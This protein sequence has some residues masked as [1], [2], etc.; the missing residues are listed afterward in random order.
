MYTLQVSVGKLMALR[1]GINALNAY[2]DLSD[3]SRSLLSEIIVKD[4]GRLDDQTAISSAGKRAR[5][6]SRSLMALS[7][8]G[9]V[10]EENEEEEQS[11][12]RT[13]YKRRRLA[14]G[15][16]S[17]VVSA[18]ERRGSTRGSTQASTVSPDGESSEEDIRPAG[19]I[20]RS[21]SRGIQPTRG[22]RTANGRVTRSSRVKTHQRLSY[23]EPTPGE[24]SEADEL[25][26]DVP[27][28]DDD[29]KLAKR[30]STSRSL[31][32]GRGRG[33]GRG[34]AKGRG[35]PK[36]IVRR[37]RQST[38]LDSSSSDRPEPTRRSGRTT[39]V[40]KSMKEH[41]EDEEVYAEERDAASGP[42]VISIREVFQPL[43]A[44]SPFRLI[45]D[46][47]C[48]VCNGLETASNK[49]TASPLIYCQGCSTSIHKVCLG[50]RSGRE[51]AVTKVGVDNFVMQ[52]RRCIGTA[53]K[54]DYNAPRL[55]I[56]QICKKSGEACESFSQKK[57]AKQ[58]EK[59]REENGGTDP[60]TVVNP[61]LVNNAAI[62]LFRCTGCQR[63]FHFEHLPPLSEE[64]KMSEELDDLQALRFVEYSQTWQ[65]KDCQTAPAKVQG[66]VA[67]RPANIDTYQ[68]GDTVDMVN[69]D[70]KEYLIKW[71]NLSHFR[72]TWMPGSWV[73]GVTATVMRTAFA[74]RGEGVNSLPK[75]NEEDAIPE[76]F[77]RVEIV[78]DVE[79]SSKVS[80]HTEEI[81]KARV[82]EVESALVKYQGLGY[83]EVVWERPPS[84]SETERCADFV[85][86]YNEYVAG[87][88]FKQ[89]Y[90]TKMKDRIQ[91]YRELKFEKEILM[92]KQPTCVTGG[93]MMAYQMEGLNWLL[94]NF[95]QQKNVVLADEMGLGK[96]IQVIA[97][98]A[99]LIKEKPKVML[100]SVMNVNVCLHT[101][102]WPFLVV[103]PN[104]TCPNWRRE[105][106]KWAPSLRVVAYYGVR[107]ARDVALNYELFPDDCPD[108]R[109]HIVITSYEA[110]VDDHAFFHRIRWAG[111]IVD[112]GQR[113]KN[114]KNLLYGALTNL[115]VPFRVLLTGLSLRFVMQPTI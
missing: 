87:K 56:C 64:L 113:L 59:L 105:I 11:A 114:D 78:L 4:R 108:L 72:S 68:P 18:D 12:N 61:N 33:R 93:E 94:Y 75:M 81:D 98:L 79:Y 34:R 40:T 22:D 6:R 41:R 48:D 92:E 47:H 44:K 31:T 100:P 85:T 52:C 62:V 46:N 5:S 103:V 84:S 76:E 54:K 86:A 70:E 104:S 10:S 7:K 111:L 90:H 26:V 23:K 91:E 28:S 37:G 24:D 39:K 67:W 32:N 21:T 97:A 36:E 27:G 69:E 66:L 99:V 2:N 58:E 95:H 15:R 13:R 20:A 14:R 55:D 74:R 25:A 1:N 80:T 57:T 43:P 42:K 71:E 110:P 89:I 51:H 112:E 115:K 50:Y 83:D 106:K 35:T 9:S 53:S 19:S 101:Q 45:H 8:S 38:H 109:A 102:C 82:K 73:W 17:L 63:G 96:T 60:I 65:C 107:A 16:R 29:T 77:K 49:G 30:R 3:E 88:Y